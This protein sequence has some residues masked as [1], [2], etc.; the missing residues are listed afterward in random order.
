MRDVIQSLLFA[1]LVVW[2]MCGPF[3]WIMRDGLGPDSVESEG[4]NALT[5]C[6]WT[7]YWGPVFILLAATSRMWARYVFTVRQ[8]ETR[9]HE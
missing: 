9:L 7:F 8:A 2:S 1:A 6:F 5:R 4:W 3:A